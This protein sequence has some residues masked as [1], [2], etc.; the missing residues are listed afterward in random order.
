MPAWPP[1]APGHASDDPA[2]RIRIVGDADM[3]FP[4]AAEDCRAEYGPVT[5]ASTLQGVVIVVGGARDPVPVHLQDGDIVHNCAAKRVVAKELARH[6]FG[7]P[8]RV[9]GNGRWSRDSR[10]QWSMSRFLI[11]AFTRLED[12]PLGEIVADLRQM[13]GAA[14]EPAGALET[15]RALRRGEE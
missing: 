4:G 7:R 14:R 2:G 10:G 5:Q 8:L 1:Q 6:I 9:S 15:L 12:D 13:A 11:T 3:Q